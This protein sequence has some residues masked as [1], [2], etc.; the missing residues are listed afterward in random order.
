[1]ASVVVRADVDGCAFHFLNLSDRQ[2]SQLDDLVRWS[3]GVRRLH[4]EPHLRILHR[5]GA[6]IS[7][8]L[9]VDEVLRIALDAL[10]EVTG[11]EITSLHLLSPD[12]ATLE[13]RGDRGLRPRL[14]E[15][16]RV[17]PTGQGL[18]GSV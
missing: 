3:E 8:T 4:V 7:A 10:T 15:I 11:H 1:V 18:I 12:G 16:N 9:D 6:A 17:L 2:W 13:L 14:R 5:I